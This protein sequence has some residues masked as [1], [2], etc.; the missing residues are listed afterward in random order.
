[1]SSLSTVLKPSCSVVAGDEEFSFERLAEH[2]GRLVAAMREAGLNPGDRVAVSLPN[3]IDFVLAYLACIRGGFTVVP[4]NLALSPSDRAYI[5]ELSRPSLVLDSE[6]IGSFRDHGECLEEEHDWKD[7]ELFSIFFTSGT[8]NRPKGVC[9]SFERMTANVVAFN[10]LTGLDASTRMLHVLPMGYMAGFLNTL[11]SPL[12]AGGC[13]VLAPQFDARSAMTFWEPAMAGDVNS[14]WLTPMMLAY[15][16]KLT[17]DEKAT[18]W[19]GEHVTHLFVGTAPLPPATQEMF[20]EKFGTPCLES[21]GMSEI[22]LVSTNCA[23]AERVPGSVGRVLPGVEIAEDSESGELCMRSPH[24]LLGYLDAESGA[25]WESP[26]AD[27]WMSTGDCGRV[28][29]DGN[30]FITD[31]IKDLI[32]RGGVNISARSIEETILESPEVAEAA[33]VGIPDP[34]WGEEIV[35]C[36]VLEKGAPGEEA[37]VLQYCKEN[38]S[39]DAVPSR[40]EG[41]ASLPRSSTGKLDKKALRSRL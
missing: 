24:A 29:A 18:R 38:L 30:L 19:A 31:R 8:T 37:T 22:L 14:M 7:D 26:L 1:M 40:I 34:F 41:M 3:G 25:T 39:K 35:A 12:A 33:V 15:L 9:H 23:S 6:N 2:A 11:L 13:A 20:E 21:Y 28:D 27:G 32:I 16:T 10:A 17:R 5:L 4:V 36:V